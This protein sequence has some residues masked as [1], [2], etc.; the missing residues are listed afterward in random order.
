MHAVHSERKV[1][2]PQQLVRLPT[3]RFARHLQ[4]T[5]KES[6]APLTRQKGVPSRCKSAP[7]SRDILDC[8][9]RPKVRR[10]GPRAAHKAVHRVTD[11]AI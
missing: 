8:A 11:H 6:F 7:A 5:V 2:L 1:L 4:L 9:S 3:M 10:K